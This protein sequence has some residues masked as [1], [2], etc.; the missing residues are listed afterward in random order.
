MYQANNAEAEELVCG[1]LNCYAWIFVV[2]ENSSLAL[3]PVKWIQSLAGLGQ[4]SLI[5]SSTR[6]VKSLNLGLA[7]KKIFRLLQE[8]DNRIWNFHLWRRTGNNL[9]LLT[10]EDVC[11]AA[12]VKEVW[13]ESAQFHS[14]SPLPLLTWFA[15]L[16]EVP[17]DTSESQVYWTDWIYFLVMDVVESQACV[18]SV[19]TNCSVNK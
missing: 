4:N 3:E 8:V 13:C 16:L 18:F 7:V 5:S 11:S 14:P 15:T 12:G 9:E 6:N 1:C 19:N 10:S 17:V 2:I